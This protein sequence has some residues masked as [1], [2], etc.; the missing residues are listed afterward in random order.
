MTHTIEAE[1]R[2]IGEVTGTVDGIVERKM[3]IGRKEGIERIRNIRRKEV[4]ETKEVPETTEG[5]EKEENI[6]IIK[7]MVEVH[8]DENHMEKVQGIILENIEEVMLNID[9]PKIWTRKEY[10]TRI[11]PLPL[12]VIVA[13]PHQIIRILVPLVKPLL[14][15]VLPLLLMK[16]Y[17]HHQHHLL[18]LTLILLIIILKNILHEV[19]VIMNPDGVTYLNIHLFDILEQLMF[20]M[21]LR[22]LLEKVDHLHH[23]PLIPLNIVDYNHPLI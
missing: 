1:T 16:L 5:I 15:L 13:L 23:L 10:M 6:Q 12:K 22:K 20:T 8:I 19:Q 2:R 3:G 11:V 9:I 21:D 4:I 7:A 17:T 14:L 18:I